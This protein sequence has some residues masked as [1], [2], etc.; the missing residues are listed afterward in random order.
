[1]KLLGVALLAALVLV[2]WKLG[3]EAERQ[4]ARDAL[5]RWWPDGVMRDR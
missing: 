5:G 4:R 1:V 3:R 2:A